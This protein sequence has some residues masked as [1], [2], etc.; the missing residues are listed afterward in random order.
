MYA[1]R[2]DADDQDVMINALGDV[3]YEHKCV[4]M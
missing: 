1:S 3:I 2:S 4:L